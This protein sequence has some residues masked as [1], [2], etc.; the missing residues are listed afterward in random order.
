M[1]ISKKQI[2]AIVA[3]AVVFVGLYFGVKEL[4]KPEVVLGEKVIEIIIKDQ[5]SEVVFEESFDTDAG[6]LGEL[7]DEINLTKE[8]LF[9][10]QGTVDSEFGR[11]I[12]A[13]KIVEL[14]EGEFWVYE[15][16]HSLI[17]QAE[18]FCPGI[19]ALPI[20]DGDDFLFKVLVP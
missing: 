17:C 4:S 13:I 20:Q 10:L 12:E 7:I 8:D 5:E 14:K 18:G 9:I 11:F 2:L 3:A 15:S 6:L 19:D 16:A 1:K